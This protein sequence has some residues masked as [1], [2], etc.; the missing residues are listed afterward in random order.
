MGP[1]TL[2]STS[3]LTSAEPSI[4]G[5]VPLLKR[6][7]KAGDTVAA[8]GYVSSGFSPTTSSGQIVPPE[9]TL[10]YSTN[11]IS[12]SA[13]NGAP[14]YLPGNGAIIGMA[15]NVPG[16]TNVAVIPASDIIEFLDNYGIEWRR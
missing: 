14:V 2:W 10:G 4:F 8:S 1:F 9:T 3:I 12:N 5:P 6:E 16:E 13:L 11:M 15:V 7:L